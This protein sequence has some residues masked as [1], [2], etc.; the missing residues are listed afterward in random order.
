MV[1][2]ETEFDAAWL[3]EK[4]YYVVSGAAESNPMIRE[5]WKPLLWGLWH[6]FSHMKALQDGKPYEI[7]MTL[8]TDF[9]RSTQFAVVDGNGH[10]ILLVTFEWGRT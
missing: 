7:R 5:E 8:P 4:G 9:G 1:L 3:P 10:L 6:T 2:T